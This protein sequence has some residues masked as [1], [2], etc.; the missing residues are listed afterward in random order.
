L[1]KIIENKWSRFYERK[2]VIT[3]KLLTLKKNKE[4]YVGGMQQLIDDGLYE[5]KTSN[6]LT[7]MVQNG[8]MNLSSCCRYKLKVSNPQIPLL[9]GLPKTRKQGNKMRPNTSNVDSLFLNLSSW[10][11][12]ELRHIEV[13]EGLM[14]AVPIDFIQEVKNIVLQDDEILMSFNV[15]SLF[16]I[17]L[18]L[19][20]LKEWLTTRRIE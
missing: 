13:M 2:I 15:V 1:L 11:L 5:L 12:N 16:S 20:H 17:N 4:K 6:P 3:L 14:S 10:L 7:R 18:T 9:Y 8:T 19:Q